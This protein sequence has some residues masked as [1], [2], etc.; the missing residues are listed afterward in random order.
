MDSSITTTDIFFRIPEIL[1]RGER[2]V[3]ASVI[4]TSGST[5]RGTTAKMIIFNDGSSLGTVGGGCVE[6]YL[7]NQAKKVFEDGQL[8]VVEA[9]LGD[10]SWSGLGMACGGKVELTVEL[11]EPSPQ[12]IVLGAG[13]VAKAI[14]KIG[15]FLGFRVVVID[16]FA[17]EEEYHEADKVFQESYED[18]IKKIKILSYD[19][20]VICT[21]HQGDES[22]LKSVIDSDAKYVGMIGSKNRVQLVFQELMEEG[23]S[24]EKLRKIFAPIGLAIGADTPEEIA[25]SVLSEILMIRKGDTGKS[26][27]TNKIENITLKQE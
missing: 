23:Y 6:T 16:P 20:I 17:I 22:A 26:K 18:G 25:V 21:R 12:L 3:L 14:V 10:D 5:P 27:K 4:R 9:D 7:L 24:I 1:F 11:I 19:N 13:H 15:K 8:R 2:F